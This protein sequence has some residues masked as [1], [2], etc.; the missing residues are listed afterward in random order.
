MRNPVYEAAHRLVH[1]GLS[2]IPIGRNK[3]PLV[4]W[5]PY[6]ARLATVAELAEWCSCPEVGLAIVAGPIS[7]NMEILDF[8]DIT[9][10]KPWYILVEGT[11]PGLVS[12]LVV[13]MTPRGGRHLYYRCATIQGNRQLAVTSNR[14][15]MIETRGQGGYTLI[16]PSPPWCHPHHKPYVL[17]QGDLANIPTITTEER[18]ILLNGARALTQYVAP[19]RVY[20]PRP[21]TA[22]DGTRPGD[23]FAANVPWED[24]LMPHGWR[25]VGHRG[26]VTLWCRP[27]KN[28]GVSATT[29]HCGDM[30]YVFSSNAF[31][32]EPE[33]AYS[34]FTAFA[35]LHAHGD[36][37]RAATMLAGQGYVHRHAGRLAS[38]SMGFGAHR[39]F[40]PF[41][42]YRGVGSHG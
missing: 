12:R 11:A 1:A 10:L 17:R 26:E 15:V 4:S 7:G 42:A 22:T 24:L 16:P 9:I 40:G 30:L 18:T 5:K 41:G 32:F 25:V 23:I 2:V 3:R 35:L 27:G 37:I 21:P 8:D 33:R 36:F 19:E 34:K 39:L 31:P 28:G 6:Q 13:V 20:A 29:G 38:T 14:K